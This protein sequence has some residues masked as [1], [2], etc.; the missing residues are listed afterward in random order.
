[1][2]ECV[3]CANASTRKLLDDIDHPN[4]FTFW[5]P[6][7]G[8]S[9]SYLMEGLKDLVDR[10]GNVHCNHFA[11]EGWPHSLLLCEGK[12]VW[13]DFLAVLEEADPDRWVSIEHVKDHDV[14]NF[15]QDAA[16]LREWASGQCAASSSL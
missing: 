10:I 3:C 1:M 12:E 16:T 2:V 8:E 14:E 4:V 5:Q 13:A 6:Y 11:Q 15:A 7:L 9:H